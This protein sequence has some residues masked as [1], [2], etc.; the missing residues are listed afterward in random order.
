MPADLLP[1]VI[2]TMQTR[3]LEDLSVKTDRSLQVS[4]A[5]YY[6]SGRIIK[7]IW[8]ISVA[9]FAGHCSELLG[10]SSVYLTCHV[11]GHETA[12]RRYVSRYVDSVSMLTKLVIIGQKYINI[13][14]L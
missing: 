5:Y 3:I 10:G 13:Q 1:T 4:T 2:S 8:I 7:G 11:T 9:S 14:R 6:I 12:S